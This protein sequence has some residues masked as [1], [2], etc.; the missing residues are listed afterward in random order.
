MSCLGGVDS[1]GRGVEVGKGFKRVNMV[2]ILV[3]MNVN[4]RMIPLETIS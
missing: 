2:Q 3:H 1:S 4:G